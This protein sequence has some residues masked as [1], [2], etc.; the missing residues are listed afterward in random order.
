VIDYV[1]QRAAPVDEDAIVQGIDAALQ[2]P[3]QL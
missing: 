3:D 2:A 1:L